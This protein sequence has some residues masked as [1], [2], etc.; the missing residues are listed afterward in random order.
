MG[1]L[2]PI[3]ITLKTMKKKIIL[4]GL[5]VSAFAIFGG[6]AFVFYLW[7]M[8]HRN[9]VS[10]QP[11]YALSA[12]S[13]VSDYFADP[14][15][16]NN[17]YLSDDGDSKIVVLSGSVESISQNQKGDQVILIKESGTPV[18]VAFTFTSETNATAAALNPNVS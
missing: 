3:L 9:V 2:S 8:P 5:V 4:T 7:N 12:S 1:I 14:G 15:A 10:T 16:A 6:G 13:F 18:G 17:K 11:D